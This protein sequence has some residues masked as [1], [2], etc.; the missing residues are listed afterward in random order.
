M[1]VDLSSV[2][3]ILMV[4]GA[5]FGIISHFLSSKRNVNTMMAT[6]AGGALGVFAPPLAIIYLIVLGILVPKRNSD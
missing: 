1:A 3:F 4:S 2:Y 5:F 6:L